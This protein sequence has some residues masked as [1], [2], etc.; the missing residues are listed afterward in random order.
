MHRVCTRV[1]N[2]GID[3]DVIGVLVVVEVLTTIK[4]EHIRMTMISCRNMV[5]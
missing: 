2:G 5:S 4:I 1:L 3:G